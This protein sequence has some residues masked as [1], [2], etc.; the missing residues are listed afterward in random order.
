MVE[1]EWEGMGLPI[2]R[3]QNL[4]QSIIFNTKGYYAFVEKYSGRNI[5]G[6]KIDWLDYDWGLNE[7]K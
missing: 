2:I 6:L 4:T 3:I 5:D 7:K 1:L